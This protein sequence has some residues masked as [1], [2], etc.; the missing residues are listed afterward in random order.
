[1]AKDDGPCRLFALVGVNVLNSFQCF[2]V[3]GWPTKRY[4]HIQFISKVLLQKKLQEGN[5]G[6]KW[7]TQV[8]LK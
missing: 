5:W 8:H 4:K 1:M 2:D 6:D 3:V 7:L